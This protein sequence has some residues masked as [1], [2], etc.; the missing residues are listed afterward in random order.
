MIFN[1]VA[2]ADLLGIFALHGLRPTSQPFRSRQVLRI[3][4]QLL[5][6]HIEIADLHRRMGN[7]MLGLP[8]MLRVQSSLNNIECFQRADTSLVRINRAPSHVWY[9][10]GDSTSMCSCTASPSRPQEPLISDNFN[11]AFIACLL[12][13]MLNAFEA[14]AGLISLGSESRILVNDATSGRPGQGTDTTASGEPRTAAHADRVHLARIQTQLEAVVAFLRKAR[15]TTLF[16][17]HRANVDLRSERIRRV[18]PEH[19]MCQGVQDLLRACFDAFEAYPG[20]M[21]VPLSS[22]GS[23]FLVFLRARKPMVGTLSPP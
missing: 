2:S 6:S 16:H 20:M 14:D 19:S 11:I 8:C 9:G 5:S 15:F 4:T 7:H 17:T 1:I 3:I 23:S 12:C 22:D 18:L 13:D 21:L 10:R